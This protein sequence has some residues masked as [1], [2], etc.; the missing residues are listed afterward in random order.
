MILM[1]VVSAG[2]SEDYRFFPEKGQAVGDISGG[3]AELL[4]KTVYGKG[5]VEHMYLFGKDMVREVPGE[6][7][8]PVIGKRA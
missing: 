6:V 1:P 3:A 4:G 2:G 7:H 8:Y 5:H